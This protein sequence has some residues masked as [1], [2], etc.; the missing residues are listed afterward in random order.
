MSRFPAPALVLASL[1]LAAC[2]S[3]PE[4]TPGQRL[5]RRDACIGQ[6]LLIQAR[7]RVAQLDT[8]LAQTDPESPTALLARPGYTFASALLQHAE[9]RHR[10]TAYL[11]SAAATPVKDDSVRLAQ[12]A[13][14]FRIPP[15]RA[16]SVESNAAVRYE[17]D[18]REAR[19]NPDHPCNQEMAAAEREN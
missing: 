9:R 14:S 16:A 8:V 18:F 15:F 12:R 11:D 6:E 5:A 2:D 7:R 4:V 17:E 3:E 19:L 1:L 10:E 13:A